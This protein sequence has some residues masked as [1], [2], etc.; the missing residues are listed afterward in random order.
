[1]T[2]RLL[3]ELIASM[4]EISLSNRRELRSAINSFAKVCS[5]TPGD[6]VADPGTIRT[7]AAKAPWQLAGYKK[8]SWA[9][10]MYRVRRALEIGGIKVH[11]R[12]RNFKPDAT[13]QDELAPLCR[14]DHDELHRFAGWCSVHQIGPDAVTPGTF[15][16]YYAY[17]EEQMTQRNPRERAH[18][19][20][21]AWNRAIATAGS[22]FVSNGVQ[23]GPPIGVEEGPPFR[24]I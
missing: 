9:N 21:R 6:I 20:R 15:D 23:K 5:L 10:I 14:R 1:M 16:R 17:L 11:R 24:I 3:A 13:W 22:P 2:L 4:E 8:A 19:A 12:R 7:L 18:V